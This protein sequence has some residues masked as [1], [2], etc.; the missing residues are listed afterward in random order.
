VSEGELAHRF[1]ALGP[2]ETRFVVDGHAYGGDLDY[3]SDARVPTFFAWLGTPRAILELGASEGA[4]T[5]KLAAPEP[6]ERVLALEARPDRLG[7]ARLAL[8]V[9]GRGNVELAEDAPETAELS[10]YGR[11]DAVFCSGLLHRLAAP[12]ELLERVARVSDRLFVD[13]H[14]A[15]G[16]ELVEAD[17]LRGRWVEEGDPDPTTGVRLRSLWLTRPSLLK[18]LTATGWTVEHLADH[19]DWSGGPRLWLGCLGR[20]VRA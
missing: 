14:Y 15:L 7:R 5:L 18:A 10:D 9:L 12:W 4:L 2:W 3:S 6:V 19:P 1:A 13:T 17:A 8:E 16:G 11:F 20:A